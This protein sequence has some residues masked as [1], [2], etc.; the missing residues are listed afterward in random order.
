MNSFQRKIETPVIPHLGVFRRELSMWQAVALIVSSTIGAGVLAMPYAIARVGIVLGIVYIIVIGFL[1][2]GL[3]L[4]LGEVASRTSQPLQMSGLARKY[5]GQ[6]GQFLMTAVFYTSVFGALLA[7][8]IGEGEALA[9]LFGGSSLVWSLLFFFAGAVLVSLGIQTIKSVEL[10]LTFAI[11]LVVLLIAGVSVPHMAFPH[12]S[13]FNPALLFFPY[14]IVLFAFSGINAIPEAHTLLANRKKDFKRAIV[15]SSFI[16]MAVYLS[17]SVVVVGVTGLGTSEV[18]TVGLGQ[19]I[20]PSMTI[21]GNIFAILAMATS[22]VILA[23]SLRDSMH[24]DFRV[25][26]RI[27][28]A[29]VLGIPAIIFF[30]GA[31]HFVAVLD[32]VGGVFVSIEMALAVLIYWSAKRRGDLVYNSFGLHHTLWLVAMLLLAFAVGTVYSVITL[33]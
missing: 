21:F 13:Y 23:L 14:G 22:F 24:W 31:R 4:L 33:F 15:I 10:W 29:M 17:F 5:L 30:A 20:G 6:F 25:P 11:L 3:N 16:I 19:A 32:I 7:Y 1:L 26:R 9:G 2:M 18:A 28:T 12:F 8:M 27:A